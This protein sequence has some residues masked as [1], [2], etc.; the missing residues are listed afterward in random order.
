[1]AVEMSEEWGLDEDYP[2]SGAQV[3]AL[4]EV[5]WVLLPGLLDTTT[6]GVL[7]DELRGQEHTDSIFKHAEQTAVRKRESLGWK[8]SLFRRLATSRRVA[9]VAA[10]L[11]RLPEVVFTQDMTFA[12]GP[13]GEP[14]QYHQ[15]FPFSPYDRSGA[16]NLWVALVDV[17]EA[18]GPLSYL[19]G[20]HRLGSLGRFADEDVTDT[21]PE[22][23]E[24][25]VGGGRA[26]RAG[27]ALVHLDLTVHGAAAN[28]SDRVREAYACRYARPDTIYT[29]TR[30]HHFDSLGITPYDPLGASPHFPHVGREGLI[31]G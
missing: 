12:K 7:L 11:M 10:R 24:L 8:S 27:D 21:Y 16:I 22:L 17:T 4:Q 1:M 13:G 9:G 5:G 20:S 31:S 23:L 30:N 19:E 2:L 6:C 29:G 25:P 18:M 28:T 3:E 14:T 26:V 15:D